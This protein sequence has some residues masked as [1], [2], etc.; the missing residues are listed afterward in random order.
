MA[1]A[2]SHQLIGIGRRMLDSALEITRAWP[3]QS[4]R[5]DTYDADAGAGPF[6][7]KCGF[8]E[9]GRV[10]YRGTPLLYYERLI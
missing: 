5:L 3:A 10:V 2:P 1:V 9:V 6:Y 8:T 7:E 4:I